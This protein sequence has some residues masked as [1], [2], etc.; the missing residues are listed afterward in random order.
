VAPNTEDLGLDQIGVTL[1]KGFVKVD[2]AM[3]TNVP[4]VY[5]IGD[6]NGPPLL[7]HVASMEGIVCVER[8]AGHEEARVDYDNFPSCTYCQPQIGSTGMTEE[9]VKAKGIDYK[10]GK[11][12][13][14]ALG[15]AK[16]VGETEGLVKLIFGKKYGEILGAHI[17]GSEATEQIA[18]I[19]VARGAEAT[20][21]ELHRTIHAHPTFSEAV[22]EAAAAADGEAIHI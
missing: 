22:M 18:E 5:A 12:P 2:G 20:Q 16:A 15:K 21:M 19:C 3:R 17:I 10:V 7:A 6:V 11:F 13:F 4:G 14:T 1:D 9:Q 8:I